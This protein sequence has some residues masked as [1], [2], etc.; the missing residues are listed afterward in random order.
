L[1]GIALIGISL[2]GIALIGPALI[3]TALI[4]VTR[5]AANGN[6]RFHLRLRVSKRQHQH[7]QQREIFQITHNG[8]PGSR[9]TEF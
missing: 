8:L 2:I 6:S 7:C 5:V 3:G 4:G 1:I 9:F